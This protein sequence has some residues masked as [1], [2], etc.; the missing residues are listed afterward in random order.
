MRHIA[1]AFVLLT[2]G[3]EAQADT[4]PAHILI[5]RHAEKPVDGAGLS[6]EGKARAAALPKLFM[7]SDDRPNPYPTPDFI[8]AAT[9]TT[10]SSR[11]V[12][13]VTPLADKLH[14][15]IKADIKDKDYEMLV[16]ELKKPKYEGKTVLVC[17]HHGE[18]PDLVKALTGTGIKKIKEDTYNLIWQIDYSKDG[19]TTMSTASQKLMPGD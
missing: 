14:L 17:W 2:L 11:P 16:K 1:A 10:E 7:K 5:I 13:T 12:D 4:Y 9:T 8:F 18:I 6:P 15:T 19:K 3:V